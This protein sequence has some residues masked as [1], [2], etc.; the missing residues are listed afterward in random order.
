[1]HYVA[2]ERTDE[3]EIKRIAGSLA[4]KGCRHSRQTLYSIRVSV[5]DVIDNC[6]ELDKLIDEIS[7][8]KSHERLEF[9]QR[10]PMDGILENH[11]YLSGTSSSRRYQANSIG[12]EFKPC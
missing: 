12:K 1:M 4:T 5:V 9:I 2:I 7:K 10:C 3:H 6:L 8:Q 11:H